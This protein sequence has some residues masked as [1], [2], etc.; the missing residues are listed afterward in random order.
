MRLQLIVATSF[1]LS[2]AAAL[3]G[4]AKSGPVAPLTAAPVAPPAAAPVAP[5]AVA[6][7][8]NAHHAHVATPTAAP[9][10]RDFGLTLN[11]GETWS[12]DTHTRA[13]MARLAAIVATGGGATT[14]AAY[15]DVAK[16]LQ[17]ELK[18][19]VRG[20]TM[21]GPNHDMLHVYLS[22]LFPRVTKLAEGQDS[23]QLAAVF[24]EVSALMKAYP[25][26]FH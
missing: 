26:Y 24:A 7:A 12:M 25:R 22:A 4:C 1:V 15:H 3:A 8:A 9:A 11:D 17:D 19:L 10:P 20:C 13:A 21:D 6:E 16:K 18:V 2:L 5:P 23:Q 14:A